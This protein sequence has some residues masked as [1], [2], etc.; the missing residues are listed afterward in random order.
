MNFNNSFAIKRSSDNPDLSALIPVPGEGKPVFLACGT[1]ASA[2]KIVAVLLLRLANGSRIVPFSLPPRRNAHSSVCHSSTA[3]GPPLPNPTFNG[4]A[5]NLEKRKNDRTHHSFIAKSNIYG[6]R[7]A[8]SCSAMNNRRYNDGNRML[9]RLLFL[10]LFTI[11][12]EQGSNQM[13][14]R[15]YI[16][17]SRNR[18]S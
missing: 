10:M 4:V 8:S 5:F 7:T 3:P 13:W 16:Y 2:R 18:F 12:Q 9:R 6:T 11:Y 17:F 1:K 14:N 15:E